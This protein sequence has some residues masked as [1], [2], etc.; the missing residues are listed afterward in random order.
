M[1][2]IMCW[3]LQRTNLVGRESSQ[4]NFFLKQ[5]HGTLL[6]ENKHLRRFVCSNDS[7]I[8]VGITIAYHLWYY[9]IITTKSEFSETGIPKKITF[10]NKVC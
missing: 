6:V 3:L 2:D 1:A 9:R 10:Q 8:I 4:H 5:S 7:N